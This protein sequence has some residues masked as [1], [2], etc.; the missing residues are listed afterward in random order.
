MKTVRYWG[1]DRHID[2]EMDEDQKQAHTYREKYGKQTMHSN[3]KVF[4]VN[5]FGLIRYLDGNKI[6]LRFLF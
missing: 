1:Q 2:L 3:G 5:S 6:T 4:S